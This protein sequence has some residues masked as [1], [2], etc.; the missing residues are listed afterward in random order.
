MN[1]ILSCL[2][3]ALIALSSPQEVATDLPQVL[4][5]IDEQSSGIKTLEATFK[6][7][8]HSSILRKPL[9]SSGVVRMLEDQVRWDTELPKPSILV[10]SEDGVRVY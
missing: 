4:Q 10:M 5:R 2:F 8:K 7:V 3:G 6:Q 9:A 1:L